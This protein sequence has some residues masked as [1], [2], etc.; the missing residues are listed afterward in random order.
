MNRSA[1]GSTSGET[2][3]SWRS[4]QRRQRPDRGVVAAQ[5]PRRQWQR[6]VGALLAAIGLALGTSL[7]AT[8]GATASPYRTDD[9][10]A[11]YSLPAPG[12]QALAV[13]LGNYSG[14]AR[15]S[16]Q[17]VTYGLTE[18]G[19][20]FPVAAAQGGTVVSARGDSV[21]RCRDASTDTTGK[22]Y[23]NADCW[24]EA[25][26]VLIRHDD[27][28]SALYMHFA[29]QTLT[30]RT[31]QVIRRGD[32]L[33]TAGDTGLASGVMLHFQV[34]INTP[35]PSND[36]GWW[37]DDETAQVR[38][39]DTSVINVTG[40]GVLQRS[41]QY[42]SGNLP[43]ICPQ[44]APFSDPGGGVPAGSASQA[45]P[46]GEPQGNPQGQS[47]GKSQGSP[48]EQPQ[49]KTGGHGSP[50]PSH[51]SGAPGATSKVSAPTGSAGSS[52]GSGSGG[53][54]SRGSG[55]SGGVSSGVSQGGSG[56]SGSSGG[57]GS[58]GSG[59]HGSAG[60][61]SGAS[62]APSHNNSTKGS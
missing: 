51:S 54:G 39:T 16:D 33:G 14:N 23:P 38:F 42:V 9:G 48:Q 2:S 21:V 5:I 55:G 45:Q 10:S 19:Q 27:G 50:G 26:Y 12:G 52:G 44:T 4:K 20:P 59:S 40:D 61:G 41:G 47:Q 34:D 15:L 56:S 53:S 43:G 25:N 29:P 17:V 22:R 6:R 11:V 30:V 1:V 62:S 58:G 24:A 31:G 7:L 28:S 60:S 37:L 57:S 46:Q 49:G 3:R 36:R 13:T 32:C 18:G 8:G 35:T